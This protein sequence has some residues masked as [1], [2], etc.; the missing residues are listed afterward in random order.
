MR[1]R[2]QKLVF[3]AIRFAQIAHAS[4]EFI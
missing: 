1:E 3:V 2:R 4:F